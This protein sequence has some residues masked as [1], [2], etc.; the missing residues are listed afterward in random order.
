MGRE[1]KSHRNQGDI[2]IA[3]TTFPFYGQT[4]VLIELMLLEGMN[5][6][7][8]IYIYQLWPQMYLPWEDNLPKLMQRPEGL[9]L[10]QIPAYKLSQKHTLGKD[11]ST[12]HFGVRRKLHKWVGNGEEQGRK[13]INNALMSKSLLWAG[14]DLYH[15]RPRKAAL[16]PLLNW[17]IP[18]PGSKLGYILPT[19]VHH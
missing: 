9:C 5:L 14:E 19:S 4:G 1:G 12:F 15:W 17:V 16:R 3:L 13:T 2:I 8:T 6:N 11:L 7:Q 10:K 18:L